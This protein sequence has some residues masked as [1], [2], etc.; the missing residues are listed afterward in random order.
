MRSL[1]FATASTQLDP[2]GRRALVGLATQLRAESGAKLVVVGHS[3]RRGS[4]AANL[5]L[6]LARAHAVRGV[7]VGAGV[8]VERIALRA[9]GAAQPT[10]KGAGPEVWAANR[11]VELLWR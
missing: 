4:A 11:R 10:K 5:R 7:L 9:L 8:A 1:H 3:D 6:S 2:R